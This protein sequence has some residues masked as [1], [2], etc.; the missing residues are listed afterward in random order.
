MLVKCQIYA[1][2]SPDQKHF[3]V[4]KFQNLGYCVG[5]TGDGSNDC[6]ALKN[7]DV[8][9]S[10]SEAEA[11]VAAPFTCR[12]KELSCVLDMIREG[13]GALVTSFSCFKYMALYSLIQFTTVSLLYSKGNNL[14]DG[15]YMFIDLCVI[16]PIAI[17]MGQS[18][19]S[20][21]LSSKR[22]TASLVSKKVLTSLIGQISIQFL[23][24][25]LIF[26]WT[27]SSN[28]YISPSNPQ[29]DRDAMY[30]SM[31][32]TILFYLSSFQY[33]IVA[34]VY[35][36]GAPFRES[37]YKNL[38]FIGS[39]FSLWILSTWMLFYPTKWIQMELELVDLPPHASQ[40]LYVIILFNFLISWFCEFKAF[41]WI[42]FYMD[43]F[44]WRIKA[45][46]VYMQEGSDRKVLIQRAKWKEKGKLFKIIKNE[47]EN[48]Y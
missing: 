15:Q 31:D 41:S 5:F 29:Q 12:E 16:I 38:P 24:Q 43:H 1:R 35:N 8:G 25:F 45:R 7:A 26:Q 22:P 17:F 10:L 11:S 34:F 21:I 2:M 27:C 47:L 40:I 6:G 39:F 19:P 46:S 33:M 3:L 42:S 23:F 4:E 48:G 44:I 18:K 30:P 37:V 14:G 13:R 9:L 36:E 32:N 20:H 28:W